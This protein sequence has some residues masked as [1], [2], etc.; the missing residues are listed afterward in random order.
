MNSMAALGEYLT[1]GE[2]EGVAV[3]L[4]AVSTVTKRFKPS[5]RRGGSAQRSC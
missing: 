1:A 2:A 4:D 3:L 5:P